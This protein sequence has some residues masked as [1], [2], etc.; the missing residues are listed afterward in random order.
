MARRSPARCAAGAER[1]VLPTAGNAGVAAAAYGAR[2]GGRS[3]VYAPR[4][5]PAHHPLPDRWS[6]AAELELLDGHIGDCGKAARAYAAETGALDLSTL[7]EPYRIEGKKTLGLELARA[8]RLDAAGRDHLPDRRR[9]RPHRHVEGL[10]RAAR[11]RLGPGRA[12]AAV[13]GAEHGLRA[14]RAGVRGR[15]GR[16]RAVARSLDGGQ[17]A[18]RARPAGRPPDAP[19]PPGDAAAARWRSTTPSSWRRRATATR[20]EGVDLSPEGGAALAAAGGPPG[21]RC[22][23]AGGAGGGLQHRGR[24]GSTATRGICLRPRATAIFISLWLMVVL[25]SSIRP[26]GSAATCC[27]ARWS[28]PGRRRDWLRALPARLGVPDV[29]VEIEPSRPLR[30]AGHQGQRAT[31]RAARME[32]PAEPHA[33]RTTMPTTTPRPLAT[34]RSPRA[35]PARRRADRRGRAGAALA[36]GAR[37]G[38][39]RVPAARRGGGP[40]ARR[41]GRAGRAARGRRGGRARST[42][43]A[44]SRGSSGWASPGSTTGPSGSG[45]G[46]VRGGTRRHPGARA[47]HRH[48]ARRASRSGPT[49]RSPARR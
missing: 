13:H 26:P 10:R 35:P 39:A 9:H 30:R 25:P 5:T 20:E 17:R 31:C 44:R 48:P 11:R 41:A 24:A 14:G 15:R 46:W 42:S 40:G 8:A 45:S 38:R 47:G 49:A 18:P 23:P 4:T 2:A 19:G 43:S 28:R 34:A 22:H 16:V 33:H 32:H 6:T 7:R 1:F 12:A 36:L 29:T 3:R 37:A 21:Q 27:S